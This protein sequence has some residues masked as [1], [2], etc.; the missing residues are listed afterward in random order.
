MIASLSDSSVKQYESGLKKWSGY[1]GKT[2][3]DM[4]E[5]NVPRV[6]E[7]LSEEFHKGASVGTLNSYR[8]AIALLHGPELGEDSR[9]KRL[10]KGFA[11]LRPT[12]PKYD[13]SWD[14]QIVLDY[15]CSW[16]LSEMLSIEKLT[17]KLITLCALVTA[18]RMQTLALIDIRN[19]EKSE[20]VLSIKIPERIKTSRVNKVQP[21]LH[22]PY[23]RQ[24]RLICAASTLEIYLEK[25]KNLRGN[26]VKLFINT[27]KPHKIVSSQTLSR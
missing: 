5:S 13:W 3:V 14:P 19:I 12:R 23:F 17:L 4:Y 10:F 16:G 20:D 9:V 11:N 26:E 21:T 2:S 18:H 7:F 24:N 27:K 6:M 15:L 8:S 25:T 22:I 1:C